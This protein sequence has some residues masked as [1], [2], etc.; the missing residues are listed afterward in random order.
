MGK[1][2]KLRISDNHDPIDYNSLVHEDYFMVSKKE[3]QKKL[4]NELWYWYLTGEHKDG[5]PK[6]YER[7]V[8]I[9][10]KLYGV[11]PG[12]PRCFECNLP[13]SGSGAKLIRPLGLRASRFSPQLCSW[14]ESSIR[15]FEGGAEIELSMLFADIR[16]STSLAESI[17]MHE[18]TQLI[19]RFY[20]A[21]TDIILQDQGMV[22]RLMGDQVIG[23]FV[24]RFSGVNHAQAAIETAKDLLLA[25]GHRDDHGPWVPVGVGVHTGPAY[26]GTVGRGE[27]V[28]EIAVLGSA[29]NLAA[30]L[31]SAARQ[32]EVFVSQAALE[33]ADHTGGGMESQELALRGISESVAVHI[34]RI[35]PQR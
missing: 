3:E 23:L 20:K 4:V 33:R 11:L 21:A 26:V 25:T 1:Q 27:S 29:V 22:N 34:F 19:Q 24:P 12:D 6:N 10:R 5:F 2:L 18:F 15:K 28:N 14:C 35:E 16:G 30:R 8:S 7:R 13:L 31:S 32:G 9:N 17:G